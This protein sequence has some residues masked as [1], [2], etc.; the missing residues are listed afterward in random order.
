MSRR[1][2]KLTSIAVALLA[3]AAFAACGDSHTRVT[4]GTY[5]GESGANAP[6]L[7]VGPLVYQV[8]ISRQLNPFDTEDAAY[9]RGVPAAQRV[10]A[11]GQEWFG[12]FMQV[13]NH[14][15]KALPVAT[16]ITIRDTQG[17]LYSPIATD[18]SNEYAYRA[19]DVPAQGRIPVPDSVASFGPTQGALLLY[20]IQTVS[21]DNR[22]IEIKIVD[23]NAPA[24]T[25]S[26]ELDV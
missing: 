21:L 24:Q 26:A 5:A 14:T 1:L 16:G 25:A 23:P 22:P 18:P 4:T 12:V 6:Y 2:R 8:Q 13:Y 20:K 19:G 15:S 10:L 3:I 7:D 11:P 9:L 17:N